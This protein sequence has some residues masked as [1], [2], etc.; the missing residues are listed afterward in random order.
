MSR[1]STHT[2]ALSYESL[3]FSWGSAQNGELGLGESVGAFVSE[4][5]CIE[6]LRNR[7]IVSI[8]AGNGFSV[9]VSKNGLVMTCGHHLSGCLGRADTSSC[10]TPKL[11]DS[12]LSADVSCL[13]CGPNHISVVTGEGR[14]YSWGNNSDGR[15]GINLN[16]LL[17]EIP[18]NVVFP[19]GVVIKNVFCGYDSTAFIDQN[20]SVWVSGSNH[21]N[22]LG[23]NE[24]TAFRTIKVT[25]QS[26]PMKL[27][28]IK[29]RVHSVSL[30]KTH[31]SFVIEGGKVITTGS[32]SDA[33]LGL[34]HVRP[35]FKNNLVRQLAEQTIVVSYYCL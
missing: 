24:R 22:K 23:L 30:G 28:S 20:G 5:K 8:C 2:L 27:R 35:S 25:H 17:V 10:F 19:E 16:K 33:Q 7:N 3:V 34:G 14:V 1:S 12:L 9:F 31:S 26:I 13:S 6:S 4:P 18:T 32:N 21:S 15:L 29:H 11:V